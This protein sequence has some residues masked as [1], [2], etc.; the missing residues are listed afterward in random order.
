MRTRSLTRD[1]FGAVV[2]L[3][4]LGV[5]SLGSF[6]YA[7]ATE[8]PSVDLALC[9]DVQAAIDGGDVKVADVPETLAARIT[10]AAQANL[11]AGDNLT[12]ALDTLGCNGGQSGEP[13]PT[14]EPPASGEP[15]PTDEAP[16]PAEPA[17]PFVDRDCGDLAPGEAEQILAADPSDPNGLDRNRNGVPCELDEFGDEP[18]P[19]GG[20][21]IPSRGGPATAGSGSNSQ[22]EA[23]PSA[24]PETGRA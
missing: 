1:M 8:S 24:A 9:A 5:L 6:A 20:F 3:T 14:D 12:A 7:S 16:A 10:A 11:G 4:T 21:A 23:I 18:A 22:F 2:S 17:T 19:S 15:S 13:T